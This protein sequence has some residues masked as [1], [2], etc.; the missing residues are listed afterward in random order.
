M[1]PHPTRTAVI[2]GASSGN[3]EALA[4]QLHQAGYRLALV[5]RRR[6]RLEAIRDTLGPNVVV[7]PLDVAQHDASAA[8]ASLLDELGDVDLVIISAG[9]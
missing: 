3:G 1:T 2:V 7:R 5:A 6:D 8:L 4:H 9:T